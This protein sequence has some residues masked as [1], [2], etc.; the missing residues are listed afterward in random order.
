MKVLLVTGTTRKDSKT[1][2]VAREAC[3][4]FSNENS[5]ELF[6]LHERNVPMME[7]RLSHDDSPPEDV[8][9]FRELVEWCD[10]IVI[11]TPEYNHSIPGPLKNLLDYL[12]SDYNDKAFSYITVSAGGFGGVRAQSHLH[13]ITLALGG[14]PGPSLPVSN[15]GDHFSEETVSDEY[16]DRLNDF[17][18]KVEAFL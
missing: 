4:S 12:Y 2:Y 5:A 15:V 16:S 7:K 1:H 14:R 18:G 13:D 8:T 11:V 9:K 10:V 3:N 6:D 17:A